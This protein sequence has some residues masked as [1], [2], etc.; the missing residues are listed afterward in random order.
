MADKGGFLKEAGLGG[1]LNWGITPER[2]AT[3]AKRKQMVKGL[4]S[5]LPGLII[6]P[7]CHHLLGGKDVYGWERR[8]GKLLSF[9][10]HISMRPVD[11]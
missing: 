5:L 8:K 2:P 3:C 6:L 7:W 4:S 9:L 11:H 10:Q 1:P